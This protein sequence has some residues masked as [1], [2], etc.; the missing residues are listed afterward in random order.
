VT[1]TRKYLRDWENNMRV[2]ITSEQ[3]QAIL[4]RFGTEP[5]PHT[6]TDQDVYIQIRNY[7]GCGEFVKSMID[8]SNEVTQE[9]PL[10]GG[11]LF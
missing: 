4:E 10:P 8:N 1:I 2:V 11:T 5:E 7:L 3:R 9:Y 6:W